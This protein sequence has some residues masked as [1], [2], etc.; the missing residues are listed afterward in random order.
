MPIQACIYSVQQWSDH[1]RNV[2]LLSRPGPG[3]GVSSQTAKTNDFGFSLG[4][5]E[6]D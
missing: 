1:Q 5:I 6:N 2:D 4:D 3:G